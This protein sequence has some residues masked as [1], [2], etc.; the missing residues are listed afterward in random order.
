MQLRIQKKQELPVELLLPL[1]YTSGFE[2][3][4]LIGWS[5]HFVLAKMLMDSLTASV[6]SRIFRQ[7]VFQSF[8]RKKKG[9]LKEHPCVS[10]RFLQ[11]GFSWPKNGPDYPFRVFGS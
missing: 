2:C 3:H 4:V 9:T 6:K 5:V 1:K 8:D 7:R 11:L 10:S